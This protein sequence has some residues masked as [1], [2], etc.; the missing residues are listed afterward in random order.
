MA[1]QLTEEER[2]D[3]YTLELIDERNKLRAENEQLK[4]RIR[5][6]QLRLDGGNDCFDSLEEVVES[7]VQH[8]GTTR[9]ND[10]GK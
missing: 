9:K 1:E 4:A 3:I 6:A 5:T 2:Q 8:R 7:I 10:T